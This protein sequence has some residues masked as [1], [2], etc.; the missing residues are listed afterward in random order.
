MDEHL[1][2]VT[3]AMRVLR[4]AD[5]AFGNV[6]AL[7]RAFAKLYRRSGQQ[8][9]ALRYFRDYVERMDYLGPV[10]AVYTT[11]EAAICAAETGDWNTAQDW[12]QKA[13]AAS[14]P[15]D[16]IDL[17]TI[18]VGLGADRAVASYESG[19]L[20]EAV[21]LL[22]NAL[23]ALAKFEPESNLQAA[24]CHRV[25]RHTILWL[26]AKVTGRDTRVAGE[27]IS[28]FPGACSNPEPVPEIVN[29][30][31]GDLGFCVV[32]ARRNRDKFGI[33]RGGKVGRRAIRISGVSPHLRARFP[34]SEYGHSYIQLES[35][36]VF[37]SIS[38]FR[39]ICDIHF[40]KSE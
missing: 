23:I 20:Q 38:K 7:I 12:F 36:R 27:P 30:P 6:P 22:K 8:R 2:D 17:G 14:D 5:S 25:V 11:R 26:L 39:R 4:E 13:Q 28:V 34:N 40:I 19:N 35:D 18:G 32:Y 31:L 29:H 1:N 21:R 33:R 9:E 37:S 15:F 3:G 16:A 10:D 24:H